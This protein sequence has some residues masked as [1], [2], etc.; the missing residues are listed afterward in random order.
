MRYATD[1]ILEIDNN[2]AERSIH[3]IN[4]IDELLPGNVAAKSLMA[5]TP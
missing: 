5:K 2:A 3:K 1:G 4:R